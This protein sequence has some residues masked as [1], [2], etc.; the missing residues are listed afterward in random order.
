MTPNNGNYKE[1]SSTAKHRYFGPYTSFK[2]INAILDGVEEKYDLRQ[3]SFQ[4]RHGAAS[5]E[6]YQIL[7]KAVL[8]EVFCETGDQALQLI[9]KRKE[10]EE[11]GLLFESEYNQCRDVVVVGQATEHT[12]TV[13]VHVSQLRGGIVAGSYSYTCELP[14]DS[15]DEEDIADAILT[16][17][18]QRHYPAGENAESRFSWFPDDILLSHKPT[19]TKSLRKAILQAC[20]DTARKQKRKITIGA[21]AQSGPRRDV[22]ARLLRFAAQNAEQAAIHRAMGNVKSLIDGP[23]AAQLAKIIGSAKAPTRIECYVRI[24]ADS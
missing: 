8:E 10:Y 11:A 15:G 4:A 21:P 5:L 24:V 18:E 2:E 22:D 7:F 14:S 19:D 1:A 23:S 17:L 13:T 3:L 9:G 12:T 6:D 16:V 20:S